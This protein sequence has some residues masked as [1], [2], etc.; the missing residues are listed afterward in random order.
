MTEIEATGWYKFSLGTG[1]TDTLGPLI[2]R[3]THA[4]MDNIEVVYEVVENQFVK[5]NLDHLMLTAVADGTDLTTEIADGTVLSNLITKAGDTST[6][7]RSTDSLEAIRDRGDL[8]W[9]TGAGAAANL[10]YAPVSATRVIGDDDSVGKTFAD[11]A[12][13]DA[14]YWSTGEIAGAI[15]GVTL[16]IDAQIVFNAAVGVAPAGVQVWGRYAGSAS[17]YIDVQ[18]K[19]YVAS[20]WENIG[21]MPNAAAD[22]VYSYALRPNHIKADGEISIRFLHNTGVTGQASHSLILDKVQVT[23]QSQV[24]AVVNA[25][26]TQVNGAA[27]TATLDTIKAETA[28]IVADT[29]ELQVEF[30]DGGRL[31]LLIDGIKTK[32]DSLIYT[33][34][35]KVDANI[36]VVND[37]AVD[38]S[39]TVGD[40][41]G[42]V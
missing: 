39:G 38:G 21:T 27:Q 35:G 6:F 3:G 40:P 1:D 34:A 7:V 18:A 11:L 9:A 42:P 20:G 16:G 5:Y 10:Y 17:H 14:S 19:D 30:V 41:W 25:N 4:T 32:T 15:P 33:V 23:A 26:I 8:A 13:V 36:K 29:N 2:I 24:P 28:L 37:V 31:D 22:A 12:L